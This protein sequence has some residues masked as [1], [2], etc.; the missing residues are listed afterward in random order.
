MDDA[1]PAVYNPVFY[2]GTLPGPDTDVAQQLNQKDLAQHK[3]DAINFYQ[4]LIT[5]NKN[6]LQ[7]NKGNTACVAII[8]LPNSKNVGIVHC[9]GV[10]SSTIGQVSQIDG[11]VL[12]LCRDRGRDIGAPAPFILPPDIVESTEVICMTREQFETNLTVAKETILGPSP[13]ALEHLTQII[14]SQ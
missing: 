11:Q 9:I 10:G 6:L 12:C 3:Q 14:Q 2:N 4:F 7:L 8:G 5:P 1:A 13:H